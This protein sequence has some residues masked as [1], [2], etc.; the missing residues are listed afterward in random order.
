VP[1]SNVIALFAALACNLVVVACGDDV[2]F[3]LSVLNMLI[4]SLGL[5]NDN[6]VKM[7]TNLEEGETR[8]AR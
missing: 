4:G 6:Y 2:A 8:G 1:A 5:L 3:T 7:F